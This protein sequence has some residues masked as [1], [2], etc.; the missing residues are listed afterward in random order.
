MLARE[1]F[2]GFAR[3]SVA[4]ELGLRLFLNRLSDASLVAIL[5]FR[6]SF[7][8]TSSLSGT[9]KHQSR[10]LFPS[11]CWNSL[12]MSVS[13]SLPSWNVTS[14]SYTASSEAAHRCA[15]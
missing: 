13:L 8:I 10:H 11:F 6:T 12:Y 14:R 2:E 15:P 5:M 9:K 7:S 3:D 4:G 1:G